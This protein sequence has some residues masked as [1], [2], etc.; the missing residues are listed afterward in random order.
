MTETPLLVPYAP[1]QA[2]PLQ[3][4]TNAS[5]PPL[6]PPGTAPPPA[7]PPLDPNYPPP[8]EGPVGPPGPQGPQG[9]VGPVGPP[10]PQGTTGPPGPQ[11][12]QGDQGPP[13]GAPAWQGEWSSGTDYANNDAVSLNGSSWYAA[14]DPALG[15]SPPA[16]PWQQIAAKGDPGATGPTGPQGATGAGVVAGGTTG[17]VLSKINATDYNTQ[18]TTPLTQATTD[19]L[20]LKLT[21]GSLSGNLVIGSAAVVANRTKAG[22]PVDADVTS[23][24]DGMLVLDTTDNRLYLRVGG[25]WKETPLTTPSGMTYANLE[26]T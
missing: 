22:V 4:L 23:P 16:A 21:G 1:V 18:W 10:G 5:A 24:A 25:V 14:G 7:V 6:V 12:V 9:D 17:Q 11:G 2:P 15:V 3:P 13:G 20:Y 26:G 19:T 8:W